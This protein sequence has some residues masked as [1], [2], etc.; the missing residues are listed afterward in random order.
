MN[1]HNCRVYLVLTTPIKYTDINSVNIANYLVAPR[2][3][4]PVQKI[5]DLGQSSAEKVTNLQLELARTGLQR[6]DSS[7]MEAI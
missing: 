4:E 1:Q 2:Q 7:Q 6:L 3:E 5:Q